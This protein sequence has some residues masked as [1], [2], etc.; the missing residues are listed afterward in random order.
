[1]R[2]N[3]KASPYQAEDNALIKVEVD[4]QT[5]EKVSAPSASEGAGLT[6]PRS[7]KL[8]GRSRGCRWRRP[9]ARRWATGTGSRASRFWLALAA[10]SLAVLTDRQDL[11]LSLYVP[12]GTNWKQEK[13][14]EAGAI[15]CLPVCLPCLKK[16]PATAL[17][18]VVHKPC[19][20]L[21]DRG[22]PN[23]RRGGGPPQ[24][25]ASAGWD[26]WSEG[27]RIDRGWR[28]TPVRMQ[29]DDDGWTQ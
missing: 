15:S 4:Q 3:A 16:D 9:S 29:M 25:A 20:E 17:Y 5:L 21:E 23:N 8:L 14:Y 1:M 18:L 2:Y 19:R 13:P 27:G 10:R 22:R 11:K 28:P 24:R 6:R 26:G 12:H 7:P